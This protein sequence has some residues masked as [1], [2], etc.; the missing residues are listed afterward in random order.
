MFCNKKLGEFA[1]TKKS[2][3]LSEQ[4]KQLKIENKFISD[5]VEI[6]QKVLEIEN[7]ENYE[8]FD[9]LLDFVIINDDETALEIVK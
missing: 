1:L 2:F 3:E 5:H 9:F 8:V 7:V 4:L 6:L